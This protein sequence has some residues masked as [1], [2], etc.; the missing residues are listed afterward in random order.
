MGLVA[1]AFDP[2]TWWLYLKWEVRGLNLFMTLPLLFEAFVLIA[3]LAGARHR[4]YRWYLI[5]SSIVVALT[6]FPPLWGKEWTHHVA[7][8]WL[9]QIILVST[10]LVL[11]S[12]SLRTAIRAHGPTRQLIDADRIV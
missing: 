4:Q 8:Y 1:L 3:F 10:G 2:I 6:C 9:W 12:K 5:A 11:A 7:P